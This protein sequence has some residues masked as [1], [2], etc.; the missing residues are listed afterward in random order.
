MPPA[1]ERND[2]APG[3]APDDRRLA[4]VLAAASRGDEGAWR[5]I[6]DLYARRVF[7][8]VHSRCRQPDLAEEVTQSV[9][10]TVA[11]KLSGGG[12]TERGRFESWLFRV[13]MNRTRDE[14][15]R[16]TRQATPTD[17]VSVAAAVDRARENAERTGDD[18]LLDSLRQALSNLPE[19]DREVVELRHHGGLSFRQIADL[20]G[21]P[22]GTLL[23]RHH[24]AL[25]KLRSMIEHDA[26]AND[27]G[28][29][30]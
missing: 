17:P 8:L 11:G 3:V 21:E 9:F 7:A 16:L 23:A 2:P 6:V 29:T 5:E 14:M 4:E 24:R 18:G 25:R 27:D 28:K 26:H 30:R 10:V 13:A 15:R 1:L 12:Y 22:M 19:A 20:L